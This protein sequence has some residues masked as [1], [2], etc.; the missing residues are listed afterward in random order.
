MKAALITISLILG[1]IPVA[2]TEED[3]LNDCLAVANSASSGNVAEG[4][5]LVSSNRI[6]IDTCLQDHLYSFSGADEYEELDDT[7]YQDDR[8]FDEMDPTRRMI[9]RR[10]SSMSRP[11]SRHSS[12]MGKT[13]TQ[14]YRSMH[15]TRRA[16]M[17]RSRHRTR[18]QSQ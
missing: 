3:G 13:R 6:A 9:D 16:M 18:V 8:G 10:P 5:A 11:D 14:S 12:R 7:L 15:S 17:P 2:W 4:E 1:L